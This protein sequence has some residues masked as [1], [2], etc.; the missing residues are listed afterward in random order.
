MTWLKR[1]VFKLV[2]LVL[3]LLLFVLATENS[4]LV[5]LQLFSLKSPELPLSWWLVGTFLVGLVLGN[6][7]S[8]VAHWWVR[9]GR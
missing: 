5:S 6:V 2:L 7:W 3:F 8:S 4:S 9:R 1:T